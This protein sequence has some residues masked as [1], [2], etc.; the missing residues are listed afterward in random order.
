MKRKT[1]FLNILITFLLF[2]SLSAH[3]EKSPVLKGPYFGQKPP[4]MAPEIFAPAVLSTGK[5][6]FCSVFSPCGTE[7]YFV[8]DWVG[9]KTADIIWMRKVD[10]TWTKP[11]PAPFNSR[12]TDNDIC[13]SHDGYRV[14]WRSWR[15][16]PGRSEPEERSFIWYSVRTQNGWSK[17]VPVK[18]GGDVLP[19]GYPSITTNGT[20]Y[21]PYRSETNVGESDIH[22]SRF[23]QGSFSKPINL[24]STINTKYIEGDMC[25]APDESFLVVSCWDRPDNN[26]ESDLYISFRDKREGSWTKLIN[27]GKTINNEHNEN[28]P[29]I[30]PDGKYFF[31]F[32]YDPKNEKSATYWVDIRS[33]EKH[34]PKNIK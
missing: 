21:F 4:G 22:R 31:F 18:C 5:H 17:A 12:Y 1:I 8:T 11:G 6:A 25:V 30:S 20:L 14:F 34:R 13:I 15:P 27:M 28:C 16:L 2:L 19:A 29:M 33:I 7:F 3:Q 9:D 23:V 26:G 32:R 24:G 10:N